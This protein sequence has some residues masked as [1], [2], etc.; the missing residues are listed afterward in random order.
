MSSSTSALLL[1]VIVAV[2][3]VFVVVVVCTVAVCLYCHIKKKKTLN[4]PAND[5]INI[6]LQPMT[7]DV[8]EGGDTKATNTESAAYSKIDAKKEEENEDDDGNASE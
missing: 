5:G 3:I 6:A 2:V 1:L 8:D 4:Q 7:N